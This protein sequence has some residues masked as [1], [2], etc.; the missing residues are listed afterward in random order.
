MK[1]DFGQ[2]ARNLK[3]AN[4]K[5]M[6]SVGTECAHTEPKQ[7]NKSFD[8]EPIT[9]IYILNEVYERTPIFLKVG[10]FAS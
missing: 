2:K 5:G 10:S 6:R 3:H 7:A 1:N 9:F 4:P 8:F